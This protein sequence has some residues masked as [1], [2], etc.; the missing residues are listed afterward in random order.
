MA[1]DKHGTEGLYD[2]ATAPSPDN[3]SMT[4]TQLILLMGATLLAAL[5]V[6]N[7]VSG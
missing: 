2:P 7:I 5:I 1:H 4:G 6:L 3:S